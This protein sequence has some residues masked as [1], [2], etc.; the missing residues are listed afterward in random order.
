MLNQSNQ[1][2]TPFPSSKGS[3]T[4]RLF[5]PTEASWLRVLQ[6]ISQKINNQPVQ[7]AQMSEL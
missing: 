3:R 7:T 5:P 2:I 1:A 4:H 6:R